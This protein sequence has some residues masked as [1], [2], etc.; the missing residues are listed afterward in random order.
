MRGGFRDRCRRRD[1]RRLCL[2]TADVLW[3]FLQE[4]GSDPE[5]EV[6]VRI[7]RHSLVDQ[8][9]AKIFGREFVTGRRGSAWGARTPARR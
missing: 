4:Q 2:G 5:F 6:G 1:L 3:D 9:S 7:L 8:L